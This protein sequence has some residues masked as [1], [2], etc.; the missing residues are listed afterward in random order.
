MR[1]FDGGYLSSAYIDTLQSTRSALK[2]GKTGQMNRV[3]VHREGTKILLE[4]V[5]NFHEGGPEFA[6]HK[7]GSVSSVES[8]TEYTPNPSARVV[9]DHTFTFG[10]GEFKPV[11]YIFVKDATDYVSRA[12]LVGKYQDIAGT[13][14]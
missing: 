2:A 14:L 3:V 6:I 4:P 9:D 13:C 11:T 8:G 5:F 12:V 7:D 10:F 1:L